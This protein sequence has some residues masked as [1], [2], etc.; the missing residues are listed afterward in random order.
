MKEVWHKGVCSVWFSIYELLGQA[1][2]IW[3]EKMHMRRSPGIGNGEEWPHMGMG[4][5]WVYGNSLCL[6]SDGGY[7]HVCICQNSFCSTT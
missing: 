2:N 7:T 3:S 6:D 4:T 5:F 1:K